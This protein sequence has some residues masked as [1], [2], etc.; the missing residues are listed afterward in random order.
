EDQKDQKISESPKNNFNKLKEISEG[1][2]SILKLISLIMSTFSI[3]IGFVFTM[4][5]MRDNGFFSYEIFSINF[6]WVFLLVGMLLIVIHGFYILGAHL[7]I[8]KKTDGEAAYI[9]CIFINTTLIICVFLACCCILYD[10]V[11]FID[12]ILIYFLA[13]I[14]LSIAYCTCYYKK[15]EY[16]KKILWF[17]EIIY[18]IIFIA[19]F[20]HKG[21]QGVDSSFI[22]FAIFFFLFE[23]LII[24]IS[25]AAITIERFFAA[26]GIMFIAFHILF[27]SLS[28]PIFSHFFEE[29][30]YYS[31]NF[32]CKK[33]LKSINLASDNV[34]IYLKDKNESVISGKLIFD[35][36]KYAYVEF[37]RTV[38][39]CGDVGDSCI[40]TIRKKVPSEDVSIIIKV[41]KDTKASVPK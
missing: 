14:V 9:T 31:F 32:I 2:L 25:C 13:L 21:L 19:F 30:Q 18:I 34:E 27:L 41:K 20:Y 37:N 36:G 22:V 15:Q 38:S 10:N 40:K 1:I 35:D 26:L 16:M 11:V 39:N 12:L 8:T 5:Y 24:F 33:F 29:S 7:R 4:T 17:T 23:A 3:I 28:V 6:M